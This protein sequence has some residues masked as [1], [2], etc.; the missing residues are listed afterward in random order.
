[1]S[2]NIGHNYMRTT[3]TSHLFF[4]LHIVL[5]ERPLVAEI[6]SQKSHLHTIK[7]IKKK[8]PYFLR[9]WKEIKSKFQSKS[10]VNFYRGAIESFLTGN[11]SNR[12]GLCTAKDRKAL[13]QVISPEHH[14]YHLQSIN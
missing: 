6:T 14:W 13:Q 12:H 10:P 1:M 5:I 4:I 3:T 7:V 11:I 9:K 2:I 8:R